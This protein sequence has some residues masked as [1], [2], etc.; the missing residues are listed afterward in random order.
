MSE[1]LNKIEIT[2]A[3]IDA[4]GSAEVD[5]T[6]VDNK[7]APESYTDIDLKQAEMHADEIAKNMYRTYEIITCLQKI[8]S[9]VREN[10]QIA[11]RYSNLFDHLYR[12]HFDNL[13]I[14]ICKFLDKDDKALSIHYLMRI[15]RTK[16]LMKK[17]KNTP[18]MTKVDLWRDKVIAHFDKEYALLDQEKRNE[19]YQ[20]NKTHM[21]EIVPFFEGLPALLNEILETIGSTISV[22]GLHDNP[23]HQQMNDIFERLIDSWKQFDQPCNKGNAVSN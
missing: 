14:H 8:I 3:E 7:N 18:L 11:Q 21:D 4:D 19:F 22:F 9:F 15:T 10:Q 17:Y 13:Y 16:H 12:I 1:N 23:T 20:N 6:L 2:Q 5:Q